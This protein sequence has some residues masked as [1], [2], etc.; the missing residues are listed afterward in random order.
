MGKGRWIVWL[1]LLVMTF[2]GCGTEAEVITSEIA[3]EEESESQVAQSEHQ[4]HSVAY[5]TE[6]Y[7]V[8][9]PSFYP[10]IPWCRF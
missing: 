4:N 5:A 6:S 1:L 9:S 8:V 3:F 10:S 2:A 7:M